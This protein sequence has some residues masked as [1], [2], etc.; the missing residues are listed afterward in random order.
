MPVFIS[1]ISKKCIVDLKLRLFPAV[2]LYS[3]YGVN[4]QRR[5]IVLVLVV[6]GVCLNWPNISAK[7]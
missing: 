2:S 6:A 1:F 4:F 7:T 5:F 3:R